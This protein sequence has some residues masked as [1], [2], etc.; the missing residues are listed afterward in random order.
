MPVLR[1]AALGSR[2]G[3]RIKEMVAAIQK[4]AK[5]GDYPRANQLL[6]LAE[7]LA[8][9]A[10]PSL[11]TWQTARSKVMDDIRTVGMAMA[12]TKDPRAQKPLIELYSILKQLPASPDTPQAIAEVER[13]LRAT[14]S[15]QLPKL[16]RPFWERSVVEN[17]SSRRWSR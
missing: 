15:S 6:D 1:Q 12:A 14:M 2:D 10:P 5:D 16:A 8:R 17:R 11:A 13:Y 9:Q 3:A 7:R 4:T